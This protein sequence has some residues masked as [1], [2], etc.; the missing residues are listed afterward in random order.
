MKKLI[1]IIILSIIFIIN[2]ENECD[3]YKNSYE[4]CESVHP[5]D[6]ICRFSSYI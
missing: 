5:N 2:G 6:L 4:E 3:Q 1:V